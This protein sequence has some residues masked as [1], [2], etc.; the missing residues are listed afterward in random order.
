[1]TLPVLAALAAFFSPYRVVKFLGLAGGRRRRRQDPI[2]WALLTVA[3]A[4]VA[5]KAMVL[6]ALHLAAFKEVAR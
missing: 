3:A 1:V 6:A 4:A 5:F 2:A